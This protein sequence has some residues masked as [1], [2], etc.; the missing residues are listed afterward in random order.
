MADLRARRRAGKRRA[1]GI[2]KQVQDVELPPSLFN[3]PAHQVP[4]DRLL[5]KKPG[6]LESGRADMKTQ[7]PIRD[8]PLVA[9]QR[10]RIPAASAR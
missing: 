5:R 4:I 10:T 8:L 6:V 1:A 3:D 9:A 7:I 2:G